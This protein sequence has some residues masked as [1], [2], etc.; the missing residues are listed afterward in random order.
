VDLTFKLQ[1]AN[2]R[3][4]ASKLGVGLLQRN[5]R[6][7]L[8][9]SYL[10]PKPGSLRAAPYRQEIALGVL[11][12]PAGL[13]W[14]EDQAKL[15]GGQLAAHQFDWTPWLKLPPPE[16]ISDWIEKLKAEVLQ[17]A[18]EITWE[19]DYLYI[20]N[21]LPQHEGLTTWTLRRA[22]AQTKTDTKR[23][24]RTVVA[25]QRLARLAGLEDA[26]FAGLSG[27]YGIAQAAPRNLPSEEKIIEWHGKIENPVQRW[28]YAMLATFGLRPHE[29]FHLDLDAFPSGD[30]TL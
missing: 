6:L 26:D 29:L 23:R 7:Y 15:I 14:A 16:T 3:L 12:N 18:S 11:A 27:N 9:S 22:I 13:K 8:R 2:E 10:P 4:K 20:L 1:Q 21:K 25:C 5:D 19:K 24:K 28:C 30:G 17:S